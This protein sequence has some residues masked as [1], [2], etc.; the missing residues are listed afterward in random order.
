MWTGGFRPTGACWQRLKLKA[1]PSWRSG[2][3]MD[4]G[5]ASNRASL[6]Q[7]RN[8]LGFAKVQPKRETVPELKG[9]SKVSEVSD[10]FYNLT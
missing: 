10:E 5:A 8:I 7:A 4:L 9:T 6:Q 2:S 1:A 3:D